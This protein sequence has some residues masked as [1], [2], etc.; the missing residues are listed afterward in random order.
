MTQLSQ[1]SEDGDGGAR[2]PLLAGA[3][4]NLTMGD[5][6]PPHGVSVTDKYGS[7]RDRVIDVFFYRDLVK[8]LVV[9]VPVR[10]EVLDHRPLV[11]VFGLPK[12]KKKRQQDEE[13]E[14]RIEKWVELL[15]EKIK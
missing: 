4:T 3:D 5:Y 13:T 6:V 12:K 9:A 1:K 14:R 10:P 11:G 2:W 8:I 15:A 7:A